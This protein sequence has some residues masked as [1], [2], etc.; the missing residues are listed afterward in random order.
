MD[1]LEDRVRAL[2]CE[3]QGL[4]RAIATALVVAGGLALLGQTP[5]PK[6]S[7][8]IVTRSLV[9][10]DRSGRV[11]ATFNALNGTPILA[12]QDKKPQ[13]RMEL[14]LDADGSPK[15]ALADTTGSI[16]AVLAYNTSRDLLGFDFTDKSGNVQVEL[17]GG[18]Q[19]IGPHLFLVDGQGYAAV[20]GTTDLRT[21]SNGT[22]TR[23]SAASLM[24]FARDSTVLWKAPQ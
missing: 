20:L 18:N 8:Q 12:L 3:N 6:V 15:L 11:R 1:E 2:E 16:R 7:D 19:E 4:K 23:R 10:V 22:T 13:G 14:T 24:L 21:P 9:I 17:L 5:R